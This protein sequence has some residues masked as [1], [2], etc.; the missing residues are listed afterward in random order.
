MIDR[1]KTQ[2][3]LWQRAMNAKSETLAELY[4]IQWN[5][6]MKVNMKYEDDGTDDEEFIESCMGDWKH[7]HKE[8]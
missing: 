6:Y 2:L 5:E 3:E 8:N 7:N 1:E 4:F